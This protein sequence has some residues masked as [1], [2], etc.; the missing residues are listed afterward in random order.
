[1]GNWNNNLEVVP[2]DRAAAQLDALCALD[3]RYKEEHAAFDFI[4]SRDPI[5]AGL[6]MG[7][8][9]NEY[10]VFLTAQRSNGP[11]PLWISYKIDF[12]EKR[13]SI[14]KYF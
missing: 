9:G 1:M 12:D 2:N 13:V 8:E 6:E 5:S 4:L 3:A 11:P 14:R 7:F 10:L